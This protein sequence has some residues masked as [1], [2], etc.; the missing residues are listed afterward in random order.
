M[1]NDK[2]TTPEW[3]NVVFD[4]D[5]KYI[6]KLK[7][8][9]DED[10]NIEEGDNYLAITS[11]GHDVTPGE[12]YLNE[13]KLHVN[14][15]LISKEGSTFVSMDIPLSQEILFDILGDSI[16][17]FNKVKTVFEATKN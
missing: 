10:N 17:K 4:G 3:I 2:K 9:A 12:I 6:S 1:E 15:N 14:C 5:D 11:D 13:G 16:K 7:K 8:K